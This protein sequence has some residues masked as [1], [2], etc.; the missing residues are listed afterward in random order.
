MSYPYILN[1]FNIVKVVIAV[2]VW[3]MW[4]TLKNVKEI[5]IYGKLRTLYPCI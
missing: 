4:I 2:E 3:I 5:A 1:V